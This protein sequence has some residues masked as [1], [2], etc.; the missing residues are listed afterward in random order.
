VSGLGDFTDQAADYAARPSYPAPLVD[1]LMRR[2]GVRAGDSVVDLGAGTGIFTRLLVERDLQVTAVEPNEAMR[3]RALDV[4]GVTWQQGTFERTGLRGGIARWAVAAQAFHW[5]EPTRAL[6]E[7]H[8]L[9][10]RGG[11]FT[12]LWNDR[13]NDES[14]SLLRV[15]ELVAELIP[16]M[17]QSYRDFDWGQVLT[18]TGD[19]LEPVRDREHHVVR[20]TRDRFLQLWRSSNRLTTMAGPDRMRTLLASVERELTEVVDVPYWCTAWTARVAV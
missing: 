15:V 14:P 8:R 20:M 1:R 9:L 11:A 12:V 16:E 19:F 6:P 2:A 17:D 10:Q 4:P 18:S 7:V 5:A 3:A 13:G